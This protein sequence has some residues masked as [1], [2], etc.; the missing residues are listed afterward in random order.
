M[1]C[2]FHFV[3]LNSLTR[4][5][6]GGRAPASPSLKPPQFSQAQG[7]SSSSVTQAPLPI[8]AG[9][10]IPL[11]CSDLRHFCPT[12]SRMLAKFLKRKDHILHNKASQMCCG[13]LMSSNTRVIPHM[14]L[15]F[16]TRLQSPQG[17]RS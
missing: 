8:A 7:H 4:L 11:Y 14:H 5:S 17:D 16:Q 2:S 12:L 1:H 9:V 3:Y 15:I 13:H 6:S 10:P